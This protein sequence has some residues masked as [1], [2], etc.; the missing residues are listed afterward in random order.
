MAVVSPLFLKLLNGQPVLKSDWPF[1][2]N[3][4][5]KNV[6]ISPEGMYGDIKTS[7]QVKLL[8]QSELQP[9]YEL[10]Q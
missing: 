6:I 2:N 10:N 9:T 4:G 1:I 8:L 5:P 7:Y 3:A